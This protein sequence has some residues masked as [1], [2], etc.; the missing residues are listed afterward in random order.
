MSEKE[1]EV[2]LEKFKWLE[3]PDLQVEQCKSEQNHSRRRSIAG[4]CNE[5]LDIIKSLLDF[6]T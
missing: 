4:I 5:T 6:E 2:L 3:G 1:L